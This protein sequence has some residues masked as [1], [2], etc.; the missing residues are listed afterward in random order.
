MQQ[1]S[2]TLAL[3]YA[4]PL[5]GSPYR[6]NANLRAWAVAGLRFW[7]KRQH[8]DG[9][10][11]EYY[12]FEHGYIP[13]SFSL[14][15]VAETCRILE[16]ADG[17]VVAA[18]LRAANYLSRTQE[19]QALNQE[20]ASIPGLYATYLL[21]G[22]LA[23]KEAAEVKLGKFC[24]LQN[25][26]GWFAEYGGADIGYLSTTLDFL[27]EYWRMSADE[28]AWEVCVKILNFSR[29]F[30]HQDGSAGGQYG[31]R[32]T[33]YFLL[34]GLSAM[35]GR[36]SL[37]AAMLVKLRTQ[38]GTP[39]SAYASFD[40]R[41]ICH[42]MMHSLLRALRNLP[43]VLAT[44]EPLPCDTEHDCYFAA[45]GLLSLNRAGS[46]LICAVKKGGVMRLFNG[47]RE[48]FHD[49][50]YR[51]QHAPGKVAATNWLNHDLQLHC[52][53]LSYA[54]DGPLTEVGQQA[55][56][57]WRHMALRLAAW[58]LGRRLIPLLKKRLIFVDRRSNARFARKISTN[59][60]A[61]EIQDEIE[62]EGGRLYP[63][64]KFSLRHVASSKYYQADELAEIA[65]EG[66][67]RV[68]KVIV[69]RRVDWA[70]GAVETHAET[71]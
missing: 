37:A 18:C 7:A 66:W 70:T 32:N 47:G 53:G 19:R 38:I 31:S 58:V 41:Y 42:N 21:T 44:P 65:A 26:E 9:S 45:A 36:S 46:H 48:I 6:G 15:A 28:R 64:C 71:S 43:T 8:A 14:Y 2:L 39:E 25:E 57:P 1:S 13:T 67:S 16:V 3:L 68:R 69:R 40:D 20:A 54:V 30:V 63:A 33:E 61:L 34:S 59:H 29:Y 51:L 24:A 35:A 27:V 52:D 49:F 22:N 62:F 23:V 10:F 4:L 17:E 55:I 56:T 50:G 12:P 60:T 5:S 11:D